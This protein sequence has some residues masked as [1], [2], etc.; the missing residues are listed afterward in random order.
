MTRPCNVLVVGGPRSGTSMVAGI[1]ARKGY[2]LAENP[3]QELRPGDPNNPGGYFEARSLENANAEVFAAAGFPFNNTWLE[4]AIPAEAVAA[5]RNVAPLP[6]HR[7]LVG[8][9]QAHP[10]WLWK[11]PRLCFT[12][13]YWWPLL[14]A[15]TT[16]VLVTS[17][18]PEAVYRSFVR[19]QWRDRSSEAKQDVLARIAAQQRAILETVAELGIPHLV[20]AYEDF[21]AQPVEMARRLSAF[22]GVALAAADL[23]VTPE[24]NRSTTRGRLA[25]VIDHA[26]GALPPG[27]RQLGKKMMPRKLFGWLY[28]ERNKPAG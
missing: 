17:R 22:T 25:T 1:F 15:A 7:E 13:R 23:G 24:L 11:D 21:L 9:Y 10:P 3:E 18:D 19:L 27:L 12:L 8:K 16:R 5:L 4:A 20:V 26:A 6:A 14:D 2:F 28:P